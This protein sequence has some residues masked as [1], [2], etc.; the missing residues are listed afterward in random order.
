[1]Q[2]PTRDPGGVSAHGYLEGCQRSARLGPRHPATSPRAA[3]EAG[4]YWDPRDLGFPALAR[5]RVRGRAARCLASCVGPRAGTRTVGAREACEL[6]LNGRPAR[7][8][9]RAGVWA[10][11]TGRET[12]GARR[13]RGRAPA[14]CNLLRLL[15]RLAPGSGLRWKRVTE[16]GAWGGAPRQ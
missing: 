9:R 2:G 13:Q 6:H 12:G 3:R 16:G 4:D 7:G 10:A 11:G 15:P 8:A 1:M 14:F 5:R